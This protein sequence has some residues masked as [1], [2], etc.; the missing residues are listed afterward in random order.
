M[1]QF[2]PTALSPISESENCLVINQDSYFHE[3]NMAEH[4]PSPSGPPED[5]R[6]IAERLRDDKEDE[7]EEESAN[8]QKTGGILSFLL[9]PI[10]GALKGIL[11][12]TV[13]KVT[14]AATS[15]VLGVTQPITEGVR[16]VLPPEV[17]GKQPK[18]HEKIGGNAQNGENPLG[19]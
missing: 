19:L 3:R 6:T 8:T 5:T 10:G 9:D 16:G 14:T 1:R 2:Y 17:G 11:H 12:P 13:G 7:P 18:Q 4:I 15:P